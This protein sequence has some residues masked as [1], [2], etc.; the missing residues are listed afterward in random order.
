VKT[1]AL[2][3]NFPSALTS[4][5]KLSSLRLYVSGQNLFTF[6]KYPGWDPEVNADYRTV[7]NASQG[8]DFYS[9]P[10][11]KSVIFGLNVGL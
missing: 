11:I 5:L 2:G 1:V 9:A 6:T 8:S 4:K 10:Q 7:T 3:Y